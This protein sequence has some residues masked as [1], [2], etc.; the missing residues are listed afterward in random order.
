MRVRVAATLAV[1]AALLP[2][3]SVGAAPAK[4]LRLLVGGVIV[5]ALEGKPTASFVA[6]VRAGEVGGVI[7]V[8][9]SW[10]ASTMTATT[11]RLQAAACAAGSPLLIGVDQEGGRVR[12]L[13]WAAPFESPTALGDV[14]EPGDVEQ[15]AG[16]AAVALRA[17]GIDVDFAPSPT[18]VRRSRAGSAAGVLHEHGTRCEARPGVRRRS[19]VGGRRGDGEAL[20]RAWQRVGEHRRRRSRRAASAVTLR[21]NLARFARPSPPACSS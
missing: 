5:G 3:G 1:A 14:G 7:L 11:A 19:P 17:A 8:G 15:K 9:R 18:F 10:S 6:R 4:P 13:P 2:C 16:Q 20:P 21:H 12:R